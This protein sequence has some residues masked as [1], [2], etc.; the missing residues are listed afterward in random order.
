[1]TDITKLQ[2]ERDYILDCMSL[3]DDNGIPIYDPG[4]KEYKEL[5]RQAIELDKRIEAAK[6]LD[7]DAATLEVE[8]NK[9]YSE[10]HYKAQ[11]IKT[12]ART[13]TIGNILKFAGVVLAT[14]GTLFGT[15]MACGL[16]KEYVKSNSVMD[17]VR[18]MNPL[19]QS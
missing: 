7:L 10:N 14:G 9:L 15:L 3:T 19:K 1:M 17:V 13:T 18:N 5:H 8:K 4:T 16:D 11:E 2:K 12:T 6:R